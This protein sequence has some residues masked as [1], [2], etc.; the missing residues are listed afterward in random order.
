MAATNLQYQSG[1]PY[2]RHVRVSGLGFPSAP[3]IS[4]EERDGTRRVDALKL[5]DVRLQKDLA[6]PGSPAKVS[7]FLDLFNLTNNASYQGIASNLSTSTAFGVATSYIP[8]RRAQL[9]VK[10]VW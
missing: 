5:V 4:A 8:P 3:T 9:G 2:S 6:M 10:F 1:K 7:L